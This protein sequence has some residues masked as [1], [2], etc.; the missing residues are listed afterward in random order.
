L[1][2]LTERHISAT[3]GVQAKTFFAK[4]TIIR[5]VSM[6]VLMNAFTLQAQRIV[7][8]KKLL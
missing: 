8:V 1:K 3:S 5:P 2:G 6:L 7:V 4:S